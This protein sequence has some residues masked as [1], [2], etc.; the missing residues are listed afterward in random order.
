M[1]RVF[2]L[3][4]SLHWRIFFLV[5]DYADSLRQTHYKLLVY[6][7]LYGHFLLGTEATSPCKKTCED[8]LS[9]DTQV[10]GSRR[11]LEKS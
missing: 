10:L 3:F 7:V 11:L 4:Y 1:L 8:N 2:S 9:E 5:H 6:E